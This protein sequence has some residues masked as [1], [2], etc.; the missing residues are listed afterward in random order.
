MACTEFVPVGLLPEIV[1]DLHITAGSAG[2]LV[3]VNALALAVG[4]P[5]LAA[6]FAR[7]D[8]RRVLAAALAVFAIGH[9]VAGL[10]PN[11]PVLLASRLISGAT[12]GLYLATALATGVRLAEEP[13]RA[14]T[15]ATIVAGISTATAF[16]V[17]ASTV[18]GQSLGWRLALGGLAVPAV[19]ALALNMAVLPSLAGDE[20]HSPIKRFTALKSRPVVIA[21]AAIVVFWGATFTVYT[22]LTPL[23][24]S[25]AGF[26]DSAITGVLFMAGLCAIVGN[27]FGGWLA[28]IRPHWALVGTATAT[29]VAILFTLPATTSTTGAVALV[30]M[31]Q[32]A[33]WSFVPA[34]QSGLYRVAG[35]GGEFALSFAV[36]GFNIGI[37]VGA[38]LGG[39][40]LDLAGLS[41]IATLG[42]A[43]SVTALVLVL[44]LVLHISRTPAHPL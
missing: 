6:I 2:Q 28:D 10:A 37:V 23:L 16:G 18:L 13:R 35:T 17:P 4:A 26:T 22:Y 15:I 36:S 33:A 38:G 31:W 40:A 11:Y 42:G 24:Q 1:D 21:L 14:R 43:L 8:R 41:A 5:L 39:S 25:R 32:L 12:M 20:T 3:T 30:A 44:A 27:I 29:T 9:I 19:L 7:A 34:A